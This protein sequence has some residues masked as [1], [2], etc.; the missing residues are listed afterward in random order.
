MS[1]TI[2]ETIGFRLY[3]I[4][5]L[6]LF[7][8]EEV[9]EIAQIPITTLRRIEKGQLPSSQNYIDK[10]CYLY[11]LKKE[12]LFDTKRQIPNWKLLRRNIL[13]EHRNDGRVIKAVNKKPKQRNALQYRVMQSLFLNNYR[14]PQQII[15]HIK[16]RYRWTYSYAGISMA[17][18][19][20]TEEYELEIEDA[21]ASPK[22][23]RKARS[24]GE[25]TQKILEQI[26]ILLEE[27]IQSKTDSYGTPAYS[28]MAYMLYLLKAYP[29]R[30]V[31]IYKIIGYG[32]IHKN[33]TKS[34]AL[35]EA[36]NF[37]EKTEMKPTSSKQM[38]RLTE[39][40]RELL[41]KV[42]VNTIG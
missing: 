33:H 15:D 39:K 4:R 1:K 12:D 2:E 32:N 14:T 5:K 6:L 23:Y 30:R 38:Y 18:D 24:V 8:V 34:L 11:N 22:R 3:T 26:S 27:K 35:L 29:V 16:T 10:L 21:K 40:G 31:D 17:L 28:R 25:S 42:G 20:L 13:T 9:H 19:S 7:T 41:K 36:H 37:V